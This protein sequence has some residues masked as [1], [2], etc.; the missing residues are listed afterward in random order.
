MYA[1]EYAN[2]CIVYITN[3]RNDDFSRAILTAI[4]IILIIF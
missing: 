4:M 2:V 1:H 3:M